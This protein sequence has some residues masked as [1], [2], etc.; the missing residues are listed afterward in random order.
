MEQNSGRRVLLILWYA[1]LWAVALYWIVLQVIETEPAEVAFLVNVFLGLAGALGV[2][3]LYLRVARI[4]ALLSRATPISQEEMGQ[5]R[6]YYIVCFAL[7]EA[8]ALYGFVLHFIGASRV[9]VAPF[10]VGAVV[11][12]L[13]C[14]PRVPEIQ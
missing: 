8:V 13:V 3:V 4:G 9:Q 14:Y 12:F 5:L 6:K 10:F 2:V 1:F 11:L 7:S